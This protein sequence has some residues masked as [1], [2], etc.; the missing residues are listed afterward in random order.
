M[1]EQIPGL[2][3]YTFYLSLIKFFRQL[4][5]GLTFLYR[6]QSKC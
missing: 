3:C 2:Y 6:G 5:L 4:N 1:T